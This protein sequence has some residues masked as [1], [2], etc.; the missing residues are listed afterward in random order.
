MLINRYNEKGLKEGP[1]ETYHENG[2]LKGK[3]SY[4]NGKRDGY[5]MLY[6]GDEELQTKGSY[7]KGQRV[8]YWR[9][10]FLNFKRFYIP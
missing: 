4:I 9:F 6:W 1:W 2:K 8:G 3:G 5:W 7:I 10:I